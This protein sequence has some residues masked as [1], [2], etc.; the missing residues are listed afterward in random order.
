[1]SEPL[2]IR[3]FNE[4]VR[5]MNQ[6]NSKM[7]TLNQNEARALHNEIYELLTTIA[8]LT[9]NANENSAQVQVSMDGGGFK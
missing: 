6:S 8:E 4:R 9:K 1:M 2:Q 3:M 5:A 7:L